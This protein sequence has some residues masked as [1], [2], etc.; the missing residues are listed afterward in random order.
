MKIRKQS[1]PLVLTF[2]DVLLAPGYSEVLPA[3]VDVSSRLTRKLGLNIPII[4]AAMDTV[5]EAQMAIGM[6]RLGGTGVIHR[7][8]TLEAQAQEVDKVK[9]SVAGMITDPVTLPVTATLADA[10]AL[11][12]RFHI[13]GVPITDDDNVLVGILTNRDTRFVEPGDQPVS[14]YMSAS[15]LVTARVGTTNEEAM[16]ILHKYRIEKLPLVDSKGRLKGLLTVKDIQK[17]LSYPQTVTDSTD[18]LL[19]TAAIGVGDKGLERIEALVKQGVDA[20]AID[21][22]HGHTKLVLETIQESKRRYPDLPVLAG[23]A[24]TAA[25]ARAL[26][27]AGADA[28]KVGV[29]AGSICTTRIVSGAGMPQLTAIIECAEEC[30]KHDVVCIADGGIKYSGDM[31]KAL[32]AGADAVMLGSMLAGLDE[33]PG[34]MYLYE[35]RRFKSYRGMGSLGAMQGLGAD[36]YGTGFGKGANTERKK[37]VPEGI[38]GQ[39][40]YRG[41]LEDIIYQLVGGLR[42]GMGYVGAANMQELWE[43]ATFVQITNAGLRESHPHSVTISKEAPN[44]QVK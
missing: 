15:N 26:V 3:N 30:H 40:P 19:C 12:A 22:A 13:S 37:L 1:F 36:R 29:G 7:N 33:S 27:E 14:D 32:A 42:A 35:G 8:L 2:D 11:M 39:V 24:A 31:V 28:V 43:K 10:E 23:N 44:Y 4:S 16:E 6:A 41:R 9:R 38:E 21:T 25:G 18:R 5:T 17:K 20:V 34:E